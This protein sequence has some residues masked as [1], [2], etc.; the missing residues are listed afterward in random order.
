[1]SVLPVC[2]VPNGTPQAAKS[3]IAGH[4]HSFLPLPGKT[5][6]VYFYQCLHHL[7]FNAQWFA[8][9]FLLSGIALLISLQ[10]LPNACLCAL[11][12]SLQS[13][14]SLRDSMDH[15]SAA[16][17]CPWGSPGRNTGVGCAFLQGSS[18]SGTNSES[19][20]SPALA[21]GHFTTRPPGKSPLS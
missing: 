4:S 5:N 9:V 15:S 1:M 21:G 3:P 16:S 18:D 20:G 17:F 14:L 13:C 8:L 19:L 11:A 10:C 6:F 2:L 12:K 7:L